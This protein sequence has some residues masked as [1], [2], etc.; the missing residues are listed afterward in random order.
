MA[1]KITEAIARHK[2][3]VK[4]SRE[5]IAPIP[6]DL[7][8]NTQILGTLTNEQFVKA[9]GELQQFVINCYNDIENDPLSWGY[10]DPFKLKSGNGGISIGPHEQRLTRFLFALAKAG[11]F[12]DG[13]FT[14]DYKKFIS[15]FSNG[16]R[17]HKKPET[18]LKGLSNHGLIIENYDKK[19]AQF[20]I[21]YPAESNVLQVLC[22]YFAD[23]PCSRCYGAC[24]HMGSCYWY[25]AVTPVTIFS[26]RFVEDPAE[27]R[28]EVEFLAMVS[29]MSEEMRE[30]Q[31]YL[32]SESKRYGY[33]FD[34]FKPV[35][36]GG[37]LYEKGAQDWPR[38]GYLGDG[39]NGDD[40]RMFSVRGHVKFKKVLETHFDKV[41]E[42]EKQRP[43]TF[44]NPEHMCNQHCGNKLS[45]PCSY[46]RVTFEIDGV[47]YHNCGGFRFL[48]PTL[49]DVKKIVELYVL[50][51]KL[52]PIY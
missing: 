35:W 19:S 38:I 17:G 16:S 34:P 44:T 40:Y 12:C 23:R 20:A 7:K 5:R 25:N 26:Y 50:E 39:W 46:H 42:F 28:N 30:I 14:V 10:P 48:N 29:G 11:Q 24:G 9:F 33:K 41:L 22:A 6:A 15:L 47:T 37:L 3:E 52:E 43:G 51:H 31:Y 27:Q 2:A 36:A 8:I 45:N 21:S 4:A 49:D 13:V 1:E 32:Y 18:L